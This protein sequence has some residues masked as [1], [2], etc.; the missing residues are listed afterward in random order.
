MFS[1]NQDAHVVALCA[2]SDHHRVSQERDRCCW[3]LG[4]YGRFG[5]RSMRT[6]LESKHAGRLQIKRVAIAVILN[7]ITRAT[8]PNGTLQLTCLLDSPGLPG[9]Y[10]LLA[11]RLA[12]PRIPHI[13]VPINLPP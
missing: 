9:Q 11:P 12:L 7:S 1:S 4:N 3:T 8:N 10:R 6:C 5:A 13:S 2:T